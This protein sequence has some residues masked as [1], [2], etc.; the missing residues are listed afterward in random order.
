MPLLTTIRA[1]GIRFSI[2]II[3]LFLGMIIAKLTGKL[4]KKILYEAEI[5][6]ILEAAGFR[7]LREEIARISEYII[8]GITIFIILQQFG[9]TRIITNIIVI[10]AALTILIS[11]LI[12]TRQFIPNAIMGLII[13]KKLK[14]YLGK[15]IKVGTATGK[16]EKIGIT[17]IKITNDQEY[18]I[19]HLY[20][21]KYIKQLRAN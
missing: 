9:I 10:L 15:K 20:T 1:I 13:R 12:S 16:L 7:P 3:T 6:R 5:N 21:K 11:L 17:N 14:K 4:V 2:A 8:Y 19:P 18:H